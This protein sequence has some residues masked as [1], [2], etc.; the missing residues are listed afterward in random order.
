M[1]QQIKCKVCSCVYNKD[2][3]CDAGQIEVA[4]CHC[5]GHDAKSSEQTECCTF[6]EK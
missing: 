6:R 5:H 1:N 2:E 3:Y 4:N